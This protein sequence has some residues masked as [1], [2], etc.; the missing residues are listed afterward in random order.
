MPKKYGEFYPYGGYM[1]LD[2]EITHV[3]AK[4]ESTDHPRSADMI[5]VLENTFRETARNKQLG[6]M[7]HVVS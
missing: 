1:E 7:P 3:G 6:N 2:G 4:D 5:E